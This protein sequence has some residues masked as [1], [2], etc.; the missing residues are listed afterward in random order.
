MAMG[1]G[2]DAGFTVPGAPI[3]QGVVEQL[4]G[5]R[6]FNPTMMMDVALSAEPELF[7][8]D[9]NSAMANRLGRMIAMDQPVLV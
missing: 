4:A 7:G 6:G 9:F 2:G 5:P 3:P 8:E 1:G